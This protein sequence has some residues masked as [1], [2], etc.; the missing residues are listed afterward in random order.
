MET[1]KYNWM[2]INLMISI[3]KRIDKLFSLRERLPVLVY[4]PA[5]SGKTVFCLHVCNQVKACFIDTEGLK[6]SMLKN[7]IAIYQPKDFVEQEQA[8]DRACKGRYKLITL[9][10]L[11]KYYREMVNSYNYKALNNSLLSQIEILSSY[12]RE[13]D[14]FVIITTQ[15]S[16]DRALGGKLL[17]RI[18]VRIR[19]EK[20]E[21]ARTFKL[22]KTAFNKLGECGFSINE[23][24]IV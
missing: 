3:S 10:S 20:R 9:D 13:K 8:V 1:A 17:D 24:G 5:G 14:A 4:G 15:M 6:T 7:K 18:P 11:T 22:E 2:V 12:A 16:G 21:I 19:L 23:K